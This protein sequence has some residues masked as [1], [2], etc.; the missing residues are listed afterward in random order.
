LILDHYQEALQQKLKPNFEKYY[1]RNLVKWWF[2]INNLMSQ[3]FSFFEEIRLGIEFSDWI[4]YADL[5]K[6]DN[7]L[8]PKLFI[9]NMLRNRSLFSLPAIKKN[10]K[11]ARKSYSISLVPL[12][13]FSIKEEGFSLSYM[14]K[15]A[16]LLD[17]KLTGNQRYDWLMLVRYF[18]YD[19]HPSGE[20]VD[21]IKL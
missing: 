14:E 2:D 20:V 13:L 17:V 3:F 12:L 18:L 5:S 11:K 19:L 8:E 9:A 4:A 10:L 15:A 7:K 21:A 6:P 1:K 16:W